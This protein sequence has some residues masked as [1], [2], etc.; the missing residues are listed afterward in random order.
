MYFYICRYYHT[1]TTV[2]LQQWYTDYNGQTITV[3]II[4]P[5]TNI[6]WFEQ[7]RRLS[8]VPTNCTKFVRKISLIDYKQ[9]EQKVT[10]Y[11]GYNSSLQHVTSEVNN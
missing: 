7:T 3:F 1:S 11:S 4:K 10:L 6:K 2:T 8:C 5:C 9:A